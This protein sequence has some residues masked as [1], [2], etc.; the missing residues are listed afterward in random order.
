MSATARVENLN[1]EFGVTPYAVMPFNARISIMPLRLRPRSIRTVHGPDRQRFGPLTT[2]TT[3]RGV[4]GD[5]LDGDDLVARHERGSAHLRLRTSG[6]RDSVADDYPGTDRDITRGTLTLDWDAGPGHANVADPLRRCEHVPV[7]GLRGREREHAVQR[8][9]ISLAAPRR[10]R[11]GRV[12][13]G[14]RHR[15]LFSQELRVASNSEGRSPGWRVA[16]SGRRRSTSWTAPYL[17]RT[18]GGPSCGPAGRRHLAGGAPERP[19]A[20]D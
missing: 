15:T 14:Q 7:R 11:A 18:T 8:Y 1:D 10:F 20:T 13:A 9:R 4:R 2:A 19:A 5:A 12:L 6:H 16:C 3:V 17:P